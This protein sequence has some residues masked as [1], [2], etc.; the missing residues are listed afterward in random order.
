MSVILAPIL[1]FSSHCNFFFL[2]S[3]DKIVFRFLNMLYC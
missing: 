1:T 2:E 3:E